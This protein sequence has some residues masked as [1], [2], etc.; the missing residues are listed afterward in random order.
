MSFCQLL[1]LIGRD[2]ISILLEKHDV[3]AEYINL[4]N[5]KGALLGVADDKISCLISE[6]VITKKA[7]RDRKTSTATAFDERWEDFESCLMLDGYRVE[8]NRII[9]IEPFI[10]SSEPIEDDLAKELRRTNLPSSE[11]IIDLIKRS[12]EEFRK[13]APDY[14]NGCLTYSRVALETLC[15]EL[16]IQRGLIV[17]DNDTKVW[18]NSIRFLKEYAFFDKKEEDAITSIYTFISPGAHKPLGFTDKEFAR[19]GMN[20]AIS[21]SYYAAKKFNG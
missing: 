12:A 14:Y 21:V 8:R 13:P 5:I 11:E 7:L 18:G 15:K 6:V 17:S 20:L 1:D 10:E 3:F 9:K 4:E 19:F 16:A 2:Q